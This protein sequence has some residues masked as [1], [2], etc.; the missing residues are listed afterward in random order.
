[1][2]EGPV[3]SRL[4][5]G[6]GR[7]EV[8]FLSGVLA[9]TWSP[10]SSSATSSSPKRKALVAALSRPGPLRLL[11]LKVVVLEVEALTLGLGPILDGPVSG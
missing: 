7:V 9:A 5:Q 3:W 2:G 1:M 4:S 8:G 11:L 10:P 6:T